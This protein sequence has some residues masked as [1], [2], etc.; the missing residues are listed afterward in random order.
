MRVFDHPFPMVLLGA[1]VLCGGRQ[2]P[3]WNFVGSDFETLASGE[4]KGALRFKCGE[5][6]VSLPLHQAPGGCPTK[7]GAVHAVTGAPVGGTYL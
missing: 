5:E 2:P 7:E 1:D 4:V 3:G 6:V